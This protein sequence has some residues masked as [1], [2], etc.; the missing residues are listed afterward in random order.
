M[1][2]NDKYI[3][4]ADGEPMAESD[5][6]TWGKWLQNAKNKVVKKEDIGDS[7]VSTVF[8]GL[9]HSFG[10]SS[11]PVLWETMVFGGNMDQSQE[12]CSGS[13]ADALKMHDA[14]K[15]RVLAQQRPETT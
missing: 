3:L 1:K 8:L 12:R 11:E 15:T 9:D 10:E 6:Y 13:R 5:L 14:M 7:K 4:N 2:T